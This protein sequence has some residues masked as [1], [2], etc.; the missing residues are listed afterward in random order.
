MGLHRMKQPEQAKRWWAMSTV[1]NALAGLGAFVL[2]VFFGAFSIGCIYVIADVWHHD[3]DWPS[4]IGVVLFTCMFVGASVALW[5]VA[6]GQLG[7]V[8]DG[9]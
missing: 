5:A 7:E 4:R 6:I 3:K 9:S 1:L 2:A 8:V